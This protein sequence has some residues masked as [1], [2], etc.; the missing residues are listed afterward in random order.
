MSKCIVLLNVPLLGLENSDIMERNINITSGR[1]INMNKKFY[2]YSN[3]CGY[4]YINEVNYPSCPMGEED[5]NIFLVYAE[6]RQD[7]FQLAMEHIFDGKEMSKF[8]GLYHGEEYH[9]EI[10]CVM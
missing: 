6:T 7:A 10:Q 4:P 5:P 1:K 8:Y 2:E 3:L 9:G